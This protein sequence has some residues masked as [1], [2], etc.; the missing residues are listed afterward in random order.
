MLG[1]HVP[2]GGARVLDLGIREGRNLYYYPKDTVQVIAVT[3][4]PNLQLLESQGMNEEVYPLHLAICFIFHIWPYLSLETFVEK[5]FIPFLVWNLGFYS[6]SWFWCAYCLLGVNAKVPIRV[7]PDCSKIPANSMDA[8]VLIQILSSENWQEYNVHYADGK[9]IGC[10]AISSLRNHLFQ[11]SLTRLQ[12]L[13]PWQITD[14]KIS[15]VSIGNVCNNMVVWK[16]AGVEQ[17]SLL[18]FF[19]PGV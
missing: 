11:W 15:N 5:R 13:N 17:Y 2:K 6:C 14:S 1:R 9:C 12:W 7:A 10:R 18:R 4:K 8:V 19:Y 3:S 16:I